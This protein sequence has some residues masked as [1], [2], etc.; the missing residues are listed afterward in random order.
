MAETNTNQQT[1]IPNDVIPTDTWGTRLAIVR[2]KMGWNITEAARECGQTATS[3]QNWENGKGCREMHRVA[4]KVARRTGYS[5]TWLI[6]GGHLADAD[7]DVRSRCASLIDLRIIPG[8]SSGPAKMNQ[9]AL[10]LFAA[11]VDN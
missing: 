5:F 1:I 7:P 8:G 3:W 11:L 9:M 2:Q 4:A 10:P 6:A